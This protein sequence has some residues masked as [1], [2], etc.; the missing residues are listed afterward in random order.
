MFLFKSSK[1]CTTALLFALMFSP[2]SFYGQENEQ[3]QFFKLENGLKVFLYE[4]HTLPLVNFAFAVNL[5]S[6]DESEETNGLVHILEHYI[7]FR[8]TEFRSG[9]EIS[10][11]TRR[12]GA[13]FNAHTGRDLASFELTL[14]SEYVD[15]ALKNQK[16]ILFNLKITQ[17]EL[18]QEKQ[19][20]LEEISQIEDDPKKY[21]TSLVYQNLFENHPYQRPIYGKREIVEAVTVGQIEK[22]YKSY[23][24]P[25][26]CAL[27][28][29]GDFKMKEMEEK[30]RE[31]FRD[32][33]NNGFTPQ[34]FE[35]VKPLKKNVE[36]EK[37]M[38]VNIAYLIIGVLGPDYNHPDQYA[39]NIL[40]EILGRG[41]NP[42]LNYPL[43][44]RRRLVETISMSYGSYM[45]G[46]CILIYLTLDPKK[47]KYA[48]QET[49]R[50][51]KKVRSENF[52]KKDFL[53]ENQFYAW[54]FLE[55]A[56]N[57][58]KFKVHQSQERGLLLATSIARFTLLN[59]DPNR[60]SYLENIEK[61]T[62]SDLR[63]VSG[64]YLSKG[65]Y[66]SVAI[67][68]KKKKQ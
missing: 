35:K 1:F 60:G 5:G 23:F 51:L 40:T 7:L 3:T 44:G 30:I 19:V 58:L 21:A 57:Q 13:Y 61:I 12:H 59:E 28:V 25:S 26:N 50:F 9:D 37:V 4:K 39:I 27:A 33:K 67:I 54:D 6:K 55:S 18:D 41:I 63:E 66:V 52:S 45:Y 53:G 20:I 31:I 11:D 34:K 38:D 14:P 68:P 56:K 2:F 49:I 17:E 48:K 36:I 43:R 10:R 22:F 24:V 46:G 29:V 8:G 64:E 65:R 42:M 47:I 16:E 15:F 62:S 32:L